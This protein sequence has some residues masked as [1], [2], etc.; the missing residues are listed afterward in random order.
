MTLLLLNTAA[1]SAAGRQRMGKPLSC[2]KHYR[3][4]KKTMSPKPMSDLKFL[5]STFCDAALIYPN[6]SEAK[7]QCRN[8]AI[9]KFLLKDLFKIHVLF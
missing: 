3:E 7:T 4:V 9:L 6:L 1:Q 8:L 2:L 5:I